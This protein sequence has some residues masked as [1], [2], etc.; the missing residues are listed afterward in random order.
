MK[1]F[2]DVKIGKRLAAGFGITLVLMV[3]IVAT[4]LISF[5]S[6]DGSLERIVTVDNAKIV[7]ASEIRA[8]LAD[9]SSLVGISLRSRTAV[10]VAELRRGWTRRG[11]S[12]ATPWK[13]L[14]AWR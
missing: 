1:L 12:T 11:Q 6:V 7:L 10:S 3:C 2:T 14:T 4:G 13:S 5:N 9:I 8:S